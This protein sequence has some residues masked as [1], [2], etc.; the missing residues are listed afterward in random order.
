MHLT[1]E[2]I[3]LEVPIA[4][5]NPPLAYCVIIDGHRSLYFT[6]RDVDAALA[7]AFLRVDAVRTQAGHVRAALRAAM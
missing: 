3:K 2:Y 7:T 6:Q 1:I 4:D 5:E